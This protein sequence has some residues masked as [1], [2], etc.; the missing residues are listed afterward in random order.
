MLNAFTHWIPLALISLT[1]AALAEDHGEGRE[2]RGQRPEPIL[3]SAG[4]R[5]PYRKLEGLICTGQPVYLGTTRVSFSFRKNDEGAVEMIHRLSEGDDGV[6]AVPLT[7]KVQASYSFLASARGTVI[8]V[9]ATYEAEGQRGYTGVLSIDASTLEGGWYLTTLE[10]KKS[11]GE[12]QIFKVTC[13]REK[14]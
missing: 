8:Q 6:P 7:F 9:N 3:V 10:N 11:V 14:Q 13:K 12:P 4:D 1:I 5:R 2:I